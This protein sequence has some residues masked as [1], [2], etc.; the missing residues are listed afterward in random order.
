MSGLRIYGIA[1]T[2]AAVI[3]RAIDMDL[4]ATPNLNAWLVRCLERLAARE[5]L[6]LKAQA[7]A[8]VPLEVTRQIARRNRL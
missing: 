4:I 6:K 5:A 2:V 1:R 8:E 3:S 7:D